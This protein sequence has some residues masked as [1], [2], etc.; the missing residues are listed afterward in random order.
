MGPDLPLNSLQSD[1]IVCYYEGHSFLC[2]TLACVRGDHSDILSILREWENGRKW[3]NLSGSWIGCVRR[4]MVL[5]TL[6][7]GCG[8]YTLILLFQDVWATVITIF[9]FFFQKAANTTGTVLNG[10]R[11]WV[12]KL[13]PS[14]RWRSYWW[15]VRLENKKTACS[16]RTTIRPV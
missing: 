2:W 4:K 3:G 6:G 14:Q 16:C 8:I 10:L 5:T 15:D 1:I 12:L 9:S 7:C 13:T 11:D